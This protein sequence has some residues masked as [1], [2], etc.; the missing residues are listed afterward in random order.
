MADSSDNDSKGG[1]HSSGGYSGVEMEA[2]LGIG[3]NSQELPVILSSGREAQR[4]RRANKATDEEKEMAAEDEGENNQPAV[5]IEA[6]ARELAMVQSSGA[7]AQRSRRA[8]K[9]ADEEKEM[10]V[11]DEGGKQE[12]EHRAKDETKNEAEGPR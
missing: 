12:Q 10:A 11:E 3:V 4:S 6:S 2:Q 8:N 7:E 9:A 1:D 5:S